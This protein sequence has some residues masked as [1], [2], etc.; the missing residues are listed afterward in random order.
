MGQYYTPIN[1][2]KKEYL[3]SHDYDNGLKL[4]EHSYIGNNFVGAIESLLLP[5]GAWYKNRIV[6]A[7]DYADSEQST[8][9]EETPNGETL[10]TI[11]EREGTKLTP[12]YT[13]RPAAFRY[14]CNHTAKQYVD[15][16]ALTAHAKDPRWIIHP[17][18][19]LTCEG[20]GRGGGDYGGDN[21]LAVGSWARNSISI[22]DHIPEGFKEISGVFNEDR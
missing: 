3:Y 22:E 4:M 15:M 16:G 18:P 1:A 17:L 14:L 9:N 6:W 21:I 11:V 19:L 7:G 8:I 12:A 20:N 10:Q 5:T 2:D 13:P